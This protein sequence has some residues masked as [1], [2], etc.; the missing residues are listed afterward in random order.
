MRTGVALL[1]VGALSGSAWAEDPGDVPGRGERGNR[2]ELLDRAFKHLDANA[3]GRIDRTEFQ[4]Q[5]PEL[6]RRIAGHLRQGHPWRASRAEGF[7]GR[8]GGPRGE[9][10]FG[11]GRGPG[12]GWGAFVGRRGGPSGTGPFAYGGGFGRGGWG[13]M[14]GALGWLERIIDLKVNQAVRRA[15]VQTQVHGKEP[16]G[17][18]KGVMGPGP[19]QRGPKGPAMAG[20]RFGRFGWR[21]HGPLGGPGVA[22]PGPGG[23]GGV[24]GRPGLVLIRALDAN[25][26]GKID[27]NEI[28]RA[29]QALKDLD[30]NKD[31]VL[32]ITDMGDSA[33][34]PHGDKPDRPRRAGQPQRPDK[35]KRPGPRPDKPEQP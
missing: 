15:M 5:M 23:P 34:G 3:D 29:G 10:F 16:F 13:R 30:R 6:A 8:R 32:D 28:A 35:P 27:Q 19:E 20:P 9:G 25:G 11:R 7:P 21:P 22:G 2:Q 4:Q 33:R 14:A 26:D 24:L 1:I 31:G 12:R 18:G 17:P